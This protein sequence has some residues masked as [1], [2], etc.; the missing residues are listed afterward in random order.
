MHGELNDYGFPY[1]EYTVAAMAN[2]SSFA[3]Y[4]NSS[5]ENPGYTF[6]KTVEFSNASN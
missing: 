5:F 6:R 2:D 3:N 4:Y 1:C